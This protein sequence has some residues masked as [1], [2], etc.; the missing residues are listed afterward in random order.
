MFEVDFYTDGH[1]DCELVDYIRHLDSSKHLD[2][3][4]VL[5]KIVYQ[6]NMLRNLGPA[7]HMPQARHLRG[8]AEPISELRPMPERIFQAPWDG[9]RYVLLSHYTKKKNTTDVREVE[10]ALRMLGDW[11]KRME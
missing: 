2:D 11:R 4:R 8:Y 6:I 3:V 9:S 7:I 10:R 5:G 1:G